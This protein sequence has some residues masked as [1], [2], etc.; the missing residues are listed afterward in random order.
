MIRSYNKEEISSI[1]NSNVSKDIIFTHMAVFELA[2]DFG[3]IGKG[4]RQYLASCVTLTPPGKV[5]PGNIYNV[6]H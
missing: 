5:T 1:E 2:Y 6:I 4:V 3:A